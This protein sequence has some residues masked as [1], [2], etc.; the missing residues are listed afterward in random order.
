MFKKIYLLCTLMALNLNPLSVDNVSSQ[1][2]IN[3]KLDSFLETLKPS[4]E[5]IN[6]NIY[7]AEFFDYSNFGFI[8]AQDRVIAI[9]CG[10][11]PGAVTKALQELRKITNKPITH[12]IYTHGHADHLGGCAAL[13]EE[14][15]NV[16]I[17]A[18]KDF[19]RYRDEIVSSKLPFIARRANDT[20]GLLLPKG[21]NGN[22]GTGA[23][24]AKYQGKAGYFTP[25]KFIS[26]GDILKIDEVTLEVIGAPSDIDD[27]LAFYMP[28]Q[29]ILFAGD[30][31]LRIGPPISTPRNERGR[32]PML[33][34]RTLQTFTTYDIDKALLGHGTYYSGSEEINANLHSSMDAIQ[35][36]YDY[37]VRGLNAGVSREDLIA[38]IKLPENLQRN[39]NL[40]FYYHS[41][42]WVTRG[43]YNNLAGWYGDDY[44]ELF[45][46]HPNDE[47]QMLVNT[48][49]G[50]ERVI[51]I[52][53]EY[54]S[55]GNCNFAARLVSNVLRMDENNQQAKTLM[56]KCMRDVAYKAESSSQRNLLLTGAASLE[57]TY[58]RSKSQ[59]FVGVVPLLA[60]VPNDRIL[61]MLTT[62]IDPAETAN[63]DEKI[64]L[65][66][67]PE[68]KTYLM[69]IRNSVLRI[70][71]QP[72]KTGIPTAS[73]YKLDL[74]EVVVGMKSFDSALKEGSLKTAYLDDVTRFFEFL[75]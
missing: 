54:A 28:S 22:A 52:S 47:A 37:I 9:D 13:I 34:L 40:S 36:I 45:E 5:K 73:I 35:F 48:I 75:N 30:A 18:S 15:E 42:K 23:G 61:G 38:N 25:T 66:I 58:D 55:Q 59:P 68:N 20:F 16:E 11:W 49:G 51:Q 63:V 8:I 71:E 44:R 65:H 70:N 31:L 3:P 50:V 32:D 14:D 57:G 64:I 24:P 12:I 7:W 67:M 26:A 43:V 53:S 60:S 2:V 1:Q 72:V 56:I 4:L 10:W 6:D 29:K 19:E 41:L 69:N 62:K 39:P 17:Y 33:W 27:G 74:I 46:I 21:K